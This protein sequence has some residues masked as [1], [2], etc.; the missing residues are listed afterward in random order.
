MPDGILAHTQVRKAIALRFHSCRNRQ[1]KHCHI[2]KLIER[3]DFDRTDHCPVRHDPFHPFRTFD[4][5]VRGCRCSAGGQD[6]PCPCGTCCTVAFQHP[7]V[8]HC[9][10]CKLV[11]LLG[12]IHHRC[13][14]A[15]GAGIEE[16]RGQDRAGQAHGQPVSFHLP[17]PPLQII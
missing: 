2:L 4:H 3:G 17:C 1:C 12:V 15:G 14:G 5:M 6:N 13:V 9:I 11:R 10:L 7:Q 8:K 16:N